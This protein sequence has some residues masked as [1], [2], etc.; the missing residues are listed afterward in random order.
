M[1]RKIH[2]IAHG[3]L[4]RVRGDRSYWLRPVVPLLL[5]LIIGIMAGEACPGFRPEGAV[6]AICFAIL[7][8]TGVACRLPMQYAPLCLFMVLG[9]LSIQPWVDPIFASSHIAGFCGNTRWSVTGIVKS[10]PSAASGNSSVVR[11]NVH[12]ERLVSGCHARAVTGDMR[13]SAHRHTSVVRLLPGDRI[14]FQTYLRSVSAE[15]QTVGFDYRRY[16]AFQGLYVKAVLPET[17]VTVLADSGQFRIAR[18]LERLRGRI[19]A[20]VNSTVA[21]PQGHVLRALIA[22]DRSGIPKQIREVFNRAGVSHLMAISGLHVGIVAACAYW[23]I[24]R[25]LRQIR[26]LLQYGWS[27]KGA[28]LLSIAPVVLY[29]ILSG[30][31]PSTQRAVI[32]VVVF[33]LAWPVN[34][35]QEIFNTLAVAALGI[36]IISPPCLFSIS[37]QLS[38][39]AVFAIVCGLRC[40]DAYLPAPSRSG[41][42]A[43]TRHRALQF[44]AVT[45][46]A[47]FGTLPIVMVYF[48][49][50]SLIGPVANCIVVPLVGSIVVPIGLMSVCLYPLAPSLA[51]FGLKSAG[52]LLAFAMDII[53]F[54]AVLPWA[55]LKTPAPGIWEILLYYGIAGCSL[56]GLTRCVERHS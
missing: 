39:M 1:M 13:V 46:C 4:C 5:C 33:L 17:G 7:S 45:L 42:M 3:G 53:H 27:R 38:F 24:E 47:T 50:V 44:L 20:L 19:S 43:A 2:E 52:C 35:E 30:M 12:A 22:G 11:F 26:F 56:L 10:T 14:R 36:L 9:Y 32:M 31:S 25:L 28:A 40:W 34:R 41:K 49:R 55:S 51:A 16:L 37:F 15:K 6:A 29:G 21:P 8:V 18:W 23:I 48:N 54:F